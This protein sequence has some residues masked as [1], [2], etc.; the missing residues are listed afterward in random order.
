M[1]SSG[2]LRF[3]DSVND[4][5]FFGHFKYTSKGPNSLGVHNSNN[6]GIK[7]RGSH[8]SYLGKIDILVCGNSD[9]GTS[10]TLTPFADMESLYFNND[11]E[12]DDWFYQFNKKM[13]EI[14]DRD[15][16]SYIKFDFDSKDDFYDALQ[17]MRKVYGDVRIFA[18]SR[19]GHFEVVVENETSEDE[20]PEDVDTDK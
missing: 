16:I 4:M 18:T 17:E 1:H 6:I 3:D 14:Y 12:P 9:P 2:V 19:E 20:K 13:N 7:Y 11:N 5:S 10:G 8:P 15:K